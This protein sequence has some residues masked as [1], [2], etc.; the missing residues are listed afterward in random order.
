MKA[1][2]IF[3]PAV[4]ECSNLEQAMLLPHPERGSEWYGAC[5]VSAGE[6]GI[7]KRWLSTKGVT[8]AVRARY[9]YGR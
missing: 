9:G 5:F 7:G 8:L 6:Y 3:V 1:L 2:L 4:A